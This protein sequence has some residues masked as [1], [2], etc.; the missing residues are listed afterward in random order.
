MN[1]YKWKCIIESVLISLALCVSLT[2]PDPGEVTDEVTVTLINLR[3]SISGKFLIITVLAAVFYWLCLNRQ[4]WSNLRKENAGKEF[5]R[6]GIVRRVVHL[7]L[8]GVWLAGE[9]FRREET[10]EVLFITTAQWIKSLIFFAGSF[11]LLELVYAYADECIGRIS[12][13]KSEC[14]EKSGTGVSKIFA[15]APF[16]CYS[17]LLFVCSIPHLVINYPASMCVDSYNQ[18]SQYWGLTPWSSH[19]PPFSTLLMGTVVRIGY[20]ISGNKGLFLYIVLQ[21]IVFSLVAG[22]T[23]KVM[24]DLKCPS[25]IRR[26]TLVAFLF[27]PYYLGYVG[28]VLKDDIYSYMIMLLVDELVLLIWN[29]EA[30]LGSK[31][32]LLIWNIAVIGSILMRNNGKYVVYP[33]M[34]VLAALSVI[35][36]KKEKRAGSTKKESAQVAIRQAVLYLALP[37]LI[38]MFANQ[39]MI[40]V[41]S[42]EPGSIR[43]TLSLPLQQTAR[44]VKYHSDDVRPEEEEVLRQM[45]DYDRLADLYNPYISDPVKAT[46]MEKPTAG[47]LADYLKVWAAQLRRHPGEY[48]AATVNHNY[49][50]FYPLKFNNLVYVNDPD[51]DFEHSYDEEVDELLDIHAIPEFVIIKERLKAYYMLCFQLPVIN[52]LSH[53]ASYVI[54]VLWVI[55]L[56]LKRKLSGPIIAAVPLIMSIAIVI[57]SPVIRY[58]PRYSFPF[59]YAFPI[60]LGLYCVS[61][62]KKAEETAAESR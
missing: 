61:L 27:S 47:E 28:V 56:S 45:M 2:L 4:S 62:R 1:R 23:L 54:G 10:A 60:V 39:V 33:L 5:D 49:P 17:L 44:Y 51:K 41:Y 40:R 8:A 24:V 12:L 19:H 14:G 35:A 42:I 43:E 32:H 53:P 15:V 55:Y 38:T 57:L 48:L 9:G 7:M 6:H 21:S 11:F 50:L 16:R 22:Y 58:S 25:L 36:L 46:F 52:L 37:I 29:K 3:K 18:L 20:T 31:K 26:L 30:F 59:I 13:P 34:A